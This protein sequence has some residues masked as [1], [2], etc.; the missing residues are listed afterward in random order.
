MLSAGVCGCSWVKILWVEIRPRRVWVWGATSRAQE[1][2]PFC[3]VV[4]A[5][6]LQ[7]DLTVFTPRDARHPVFAK[8]CGPCLAG[9]IRPIAG[10]RQ[11]HRSFS[12]SV[13]AAIQKQDP[14]LIGRTAA[15]RFPLHPLWHAQLCLAELCVH[16]SGRARSSSRAKLAEQ[17]HGCVPN[18][19]ERRPSGTNRVRL[20]LSRLSDLWGRNGSCAC[21]SWDT[22]G[23]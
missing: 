8:S 16:L 4:P 7:S 10:V 22:I 19:F 2:T 23:R 11:C 14:R 3:T 9:P 17:D 12:P 1:A 21:V 5:G 6:P 20:R 13:P 18:R 15:A